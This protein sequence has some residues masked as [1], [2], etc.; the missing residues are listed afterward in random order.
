[1]INA[2]AGF[3]KRRISVIIS[4]GYEGMGVIVLYQ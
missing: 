4:Y 3:Q 1:M 2:G